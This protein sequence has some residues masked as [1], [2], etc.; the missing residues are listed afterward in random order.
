MFLLLNAIIPRV[1]SSYLTPPE[2][3]TLG[4]VFLAGPLPTQI[5]QLSRLH[6]LWVSVLAATEAIVI[7][8]E[9]T[10]LSNIRTLHLEGIA[11]P[12]DTWFT[13]AFVAMTGLAMLSVGNDANPFGHDSSTLPTEIGRLAALESLTFVNDGWTGTFPTELARLTILTSLELSSNPFTG[14][15]PTELGLL[16]DLVVLDLSDNSLLTGFV[17]SEI[18][19]LTNLSI[20]NFVMTKLSQQIPPEVCAFGIEV[21][22]SKDPNNCYNPAFIDACK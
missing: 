21:R 13:D 9:V 17:P 3:L 16:T 19:A 22:M 5:G 12:S 1:T 14:T 8:S 15:I 7:P 6:T 10:L 4:S 18:G 20:A 11:T 2:S